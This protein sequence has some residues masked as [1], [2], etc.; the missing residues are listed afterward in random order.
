MLSAKLIHRFYSIF[1][2]I[3]VTIKLKNILLHKIIFMTCFPH[4]VLILCEGFE[5][6]MNHIAFNNPDMDKLL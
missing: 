5:I 1:S 2:T 4:C 3:N 6:F